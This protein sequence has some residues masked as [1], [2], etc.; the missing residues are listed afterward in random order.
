MPGLQTRIPGS[1]SV[2]FRHLSDGFPAGRLSYPRIQLTPIWR[3]PDLD[4]ATGWNVGSHGTIALDT[5]NVQVS[6]AATPASVKCT[7]TGIGAPECGCYKSG[8]TIPDLT[9]GIVRVKFRVND[10]PASLNDGT[11]TLTDNVSSYIR[12]TVLD[13][14]FEEYFGSGWY[15]WWAPISR[16]SGSAN[17]AALVRVEF[18]WHTKGLVAGVSV[19]VDDLAVFA[20]PTRVPRHFITF[21]DGLAGHF[22][23]ACYMASK[24]VF[25]T[26]FIITSK[27]GTAGY[28][29]LDQL[30][31]LRDMGHLVANHSS[32]HNYGSL[33][34]FQQEADEAA[35]WLTRNGFRGGLCYAIPGG[36]NNDLM[37]DSRWESWLNRFDVVRQTYS[38][39]EGDVISPARSR[40]LYAQAFDYTEA[41]SRAI[42]DR[43]IASNLD[44]CIGFHHPETTTNFNT[45]IDYC[46]TLQNAGSLR[47]CTVDQFATSI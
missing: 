29:T 21:D 26:F 45:Y 19:T 7:S 16:F 20:K 17:L 5:A 27:I 11:I 31:R 1:K 37:V 28:L 4:A 14:T 22:P 32:G 34:V 46:A 42:V 43:S 10:L 41:N 36:T 24:G 2:Q 30:K 15:E 25:G 13:T 40:L 8:L 33:D 18:V 3:L 44:T 35:D 39:T 12:R 47:C 9:N 23:A 38:V 6:A